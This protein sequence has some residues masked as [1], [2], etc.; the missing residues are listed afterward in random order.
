MPAVA[1]YAGNGL[2]CKD[3]LD[4]RK[5]VLEERTGLNLIFLKG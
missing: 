1:Q 2:L 3:P 5:S 4:N